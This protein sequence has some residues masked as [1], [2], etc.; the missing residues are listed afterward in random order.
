VETVTDKKGFLVRKILVGGQLY[1]LQGQQL[2]TITGQRV[3]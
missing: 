1:I 2:F 3:K